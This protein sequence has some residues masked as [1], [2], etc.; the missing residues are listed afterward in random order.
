M[1]IQNFFLSFCIV[2]L[3]SCNPAEEQHSNQSF[4]SINS[5]VSQTPKEVVRAW[6]SLLD[7]YELD[8]AK[9]IASPEAQQFLDLLASYG[10]GLPKDSLI[11]ASEILKIECVEGQN[12]ATCYTLIRDLTFKEIYRDTFDLILEGNN[13]LITIRQE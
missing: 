2:L 8:Q 10:N 6:Q 1:N 11:T 3:C 13:W 12:Q 5:F 4:A 9:S 7:A